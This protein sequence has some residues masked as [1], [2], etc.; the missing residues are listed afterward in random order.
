MNRKSCFRVGTSLLACGIVVLGMYAVTRAVLR[1]EIDGL[2][3]RI[4]AISLQLDS[5]VDGDEAVYSRGDVLTSIEEVRG[6]LTGLRKGRYSVS[7]VSSILF[8]LY[9]LLTICG[10]LLLVFAARLARSSEP[11]GDG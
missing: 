10:S 11:V 2:S 6:E 4:D 1:R 8:Y 3:D 9:A 7:M 5:L